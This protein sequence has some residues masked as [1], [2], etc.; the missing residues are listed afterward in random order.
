[1]FLR[2]VNECLICKKPL[3]SHQPVITED[4]GQL[5]ECS[6]I[7]DII[8]DSNDFETLERIAWD[9]VDI[10]ATKI[11]LKQLIPLLATHPHSDIRLAFA[12]SLD[13]LLYHGYDVDKWLFKLARDQD[14]EVASR[15]LWCLPAIAHFR[16]S[17]VFPVFDILMSRSIELKI[18]CLKMLSEIPPDKVD[19]NPFL[20][21]AIAEPK[22]TLRDM[23]GKIMLHLSSNGINI[24]TA[25]KAGLQVS[26]P[27]EFKV[28]CV[29][30]LVN[31]LPTYFNDLKEDAL[32]VLSHD[33]EKVRATAVRILPI[34]A[35]K[36]LDIS[37][38]VTSFLK[39]ESVG[40]R[41]QLAWI[42][43]ELADSNIPAQQ[44]KQILES[45]ARDNHPEVCVELI[46]RLPDLKEREYDIE[47]LLTVL[48]ARSEPEIKVAI[49]SQLA[50]LSY[51]GMTVIDLFDH[52]LQD[53]DT[54]VRKMLA[55]VFPRIGGTSNLPVFQ[56]FKTLAEDPSPEVRAEIINQLERIINKCLNA[57]VSVD[58]L[59]QGLIALSDS[60]SKEQRMILSKVV[61]QLFNKQLLDEF[62][63]TLL[64]MATE[65][66]ISS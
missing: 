63:A 13:S 2:E 3:K 6:K 57:H 53:L 23:A 43:P 5:L 7:T 60:A 20:V 65:G 49:C 26:D 37:E 59:Y 24:C 47:P 40:V 29:R 44:M 54:K 48:T 19:L 14:E 15:I 11:D 45:L 9:L 64:L 66:F 18:K 4:Q 55:K 51:T 36:E 31:L 10:A 61:R 32:C 8:Q 52:Y 35:T 25:I 58:D 12:R 46:Y 38:Y 33:E 21:R 22:R 27:I 30:S 56:R 28:A 42:L 17:L 41:S 34:F 16:P 62:Q 50:R 1:M 39:D